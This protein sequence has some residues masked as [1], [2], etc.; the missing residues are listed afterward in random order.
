MESTYHILSSL[1]LTC[2][3]C[4]HKRCGLPSIVPV[5]QTVR[6]AHAPISCLNQCFHPLL[7]IAGCA[8]TAYGTLFQARTYTIS[9]T[10]AIASP[11][12]VLLG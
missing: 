5:G 7:Q 10:N 8:L 11:C 1:A 4:S 3:Q 2:S 9:A 6:H 12:F